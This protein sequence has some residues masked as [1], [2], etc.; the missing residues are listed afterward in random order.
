[1]IA[2]SARAKNHRLES[3]RGV[4]PLLSARLITR[5]HGLVEASWSFIVKPTDF[6]VPE[7]F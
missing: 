1:M 7:A 5:L 2:V 4:R 6:V 3:M